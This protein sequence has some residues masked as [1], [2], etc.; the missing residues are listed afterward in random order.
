MIL[1]EV[2]SLAI[3]A[4]CLHTAHS[5][6]YRICIYTYTTSTLS[7]RFGHWKAG[8]KFT[9]CLWYKAILTGLQ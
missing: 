7:D 6:M 1:S 3:F 2:A 8:G 9:L 4:V 5:V